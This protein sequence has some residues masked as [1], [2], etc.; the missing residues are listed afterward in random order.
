MNNNNQ[1]NNQNINQVNNTNT[2]MYYQ[3]NNVVYPPVN[4]VQPQPVN[5]QP[6]SPN[7]EIKPPEK[8]S[9]SVVYLLIFIIVLLGG[10]LFFISSS[11]SKIIENLKYSCSPVYE[12]EKT[13]LDVN[14]TLVQELYSKVKQHKDAKKYKITTKNKLKNVLKNLEKDGKIFVSENDEV[15][16]IS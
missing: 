4:N 9:N 3:N 14:S 10:A 7:Q 11:N 1:V 12:T 6:I 8:K 15:T 13:E 5:Y 16:L 2:G